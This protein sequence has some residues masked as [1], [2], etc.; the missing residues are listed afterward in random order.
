MDYK[1]KI[2]DS[3]ERDLD[4]ILTYIIH[5]LDNLDAALK[6]SDEINDRYKKL[7]ENPY[8]YPMCIDPRIKLLG[9]RRIVI[10]G[11]LLLYR[12]D[13]ELKIVFVE[14]FF[15]QLQDYAAKI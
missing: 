15:S 9:Y 10:G 4:E 6:L 5:E 7:K 3:A 13:Q 11:F 1:L 8:L 14:R 12:I 2:T